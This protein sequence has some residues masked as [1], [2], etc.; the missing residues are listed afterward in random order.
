M[1]KTEKKIYVLRGGKKV[2]ENYITKSRL[3]TADIYDGLKSSPLPTK[4]NHRMAEA[5]RNMSNSEY[6][7]YFGIVSYHYYK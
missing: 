6:I 5:I 7:N 3:G 4:V 2:S 1:K